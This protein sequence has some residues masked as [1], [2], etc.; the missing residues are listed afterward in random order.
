MPLAGVPQT[1]QNDAIRIDE[2]ARS[3][4]P[5]ARSMNMQGR[6]TKISTENI[7]DALAELAYL[8]VWYSAEVCGGK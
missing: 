5:F 1:K 6:R 7:L 2:S 3:I 4:F 8:A